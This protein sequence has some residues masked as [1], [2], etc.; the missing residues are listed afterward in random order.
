MLACGIIMILMIFVKNFLMIMIARFFLGFFEAG[1]IPGMI[2]YITI[3]YKRSEQNSRVSAVLWGPTFAGAL[4]GLLSYAIISLL[5]SKAGLSGW[6]W[7]FLVCGVITIIVS[8]V[9]YFLIFDS[10]DNVKWLNNEERKR[11]SAG[12]KRDGLQDTEEI[13][14]DLVLECLK[15]WKVCVSMFIFCGISVATYSFSFFIPSIINGFGFNEVLSQLLVVPPFI[16]GCIS[17]I[18]VAF[19]SDRA[20]LRGPYVILFA[21]IG[22]VGYAIVGTIQSHAIFKYIGTMFI[23]IGAF[24]CR[25]TSTKWLA[26]NIPPSLK[27]NIGISLMVGSGGIGGIIATQIYRSVDYP[28]YYLGHLVAS[29]CLFLAILLSI[30]QFTILKINN[31][32]MKK[33][34]KKIRR[35][36]SWNSESE[37]GHFL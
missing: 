15:D 10:V 31:D 1:L 28:N 17:E 21:S 35:A 6:Q 22:M 4:S 16:L 14:K 12:I 5:D 30:I 2:Y 37:F 20:N 36:V 25:A 33:Q 24:P 3:W 34:R 7:I 9:A 27:R 8:I 18:G 29:I 13:S 26:N 11:V 23:A 19:L 32:K